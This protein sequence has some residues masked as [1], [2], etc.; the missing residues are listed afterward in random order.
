MPSPHSPI[1]GPYRIERRLGHGG[2][3][4]VFLVT[5]GQ[6]PFEA[7]FALKRMHAGDGD[8]ARAALFREETKI[9]TGLAHRNVVRAVDFNQDDDGGF[10]LVME[11]VDGPT[12][13]QLMD[14]RRL[15]ISL[16]VHIAQEICRGLSYCHDY[17][18]HRHLE[19]IV[20][21]DIKPENIL[22]DADGTVKVA[23]FGIARFRGRES[24][25]ATDQFRGTPWYMSPEH[26]DP[27]RGLDHRSDLFSLGVVLYELIANINPFRK[28]R[29]SS[30]EHAI[31]AILIDGRFAPVE[32]RVPTLE[33]ELSALVN[34]LL[35]QHPDARPA[36]AHEVLQR[37]IRLP[38]RADANELLVEYVA[39]LHQR[40][41]RRR[42]D[43]DP[44]KLAVPA[45][46]VTG[47]PML[48]DDAADALEESGTF[49]PSAVLAHTD[50]P[51]SSSSERGALRRDRQV[52]P[53]LERPRT[54]GVRAWAVGLGLI[55]I[56]GAGTAMVA[57][58]RPRA[59]RDE[60]TPMASLVVPRAAANSDE[61]QPSVVSGT[62]TE[63]ARDPRAMTAPPREPVQ[64]TT[65]TAQP[66]NSPTPP[67]PTPH[68]H[69]E[70][71][72][73][74]PTPGVGTPGVPMEERP[75]KRSPQEGLAQLHVIVYPWGYVWV[76]GV[77][78]GES[79]ADL[80][81][82]SPG[83]HVVGIGQS[84]DGPTKTFRVRLKPG[85]NEQEYS[86]R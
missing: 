45:V 41:A 3:G 35:Q 80:P 7:R 58:G 67:P 12:L 64:I 53:V 85:A 61:R 33:P 23:D 56:V 63:G 1:V 81:R 19:E 83:R 18:R 86:L 6:R 27:E 47:A 34:Q 49:D 38:Q 10:Y 4:Q 69:V 68:A 11:Y 5:K 20:H 77:L 84:V 36:S 74:A 30:A 59:Q 70:S 62:L 32:E 26:M 54:G 29:G 50:S 25:T 15:P 21:R 73:G 66:L 9:M 82:I 46:T 65:P 31:K 72:P 44:H 17:A 76:D 13:K 14:H 42:D 37:L 43:T 52:T 28:D 39:T 57:I 8:E 55:T 51:P 60:S 75:S 48:D 16:I 71:T 24:H 22:I 78:R 2:M 79:P 40:E